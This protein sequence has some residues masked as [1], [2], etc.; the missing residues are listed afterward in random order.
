MTDFS[1]TCNSFYFKNILL[2]L[3]Y[4]V[5][6]KR[7]ANMSHVDAKIQRLLIPSLLSEQFQCFMKFPPFSSLG[8]ISIQNQDYSLVGH[9]TF[10]PS[11]GCTSKRFLLILFPLN[12]FPFS[13][14]ATYSHYP[15]LKFIP[16]CLLGKSS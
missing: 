13:D 1:K 11:D 12:I 3:L 8:E 4:L 7:F 5:L 15:K 16:V 9:S 14:G 2:I 10:V 6:I